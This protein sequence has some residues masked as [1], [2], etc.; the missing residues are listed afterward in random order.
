MLRPGIGLLTD[1]SLDSSWCWPS[2][3]Q[4]H[5]CLTANAASSGSAGRSPAALPEQGG[6]CFTV[7]GQ[8]RSY[9]ALPKAFLGGSSSKQARLSDQ[10][11]ITGQGEV[12]VY[13]PCPQAGGEKVSPVHFRAGAAICPWYVS[14]PDHGAPSEPDPTH[15]AARSAPLTHRR[16]PSEK[17]LPLGIPARP[18]S[19]RSPSG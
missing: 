17:P 6:A 19:A 9:T 11:N 18:L 15:N 7:A 16:L 14:L 5:T 4:R 1:T 10:V 12:P 13:F 2:P 3:S 8:W